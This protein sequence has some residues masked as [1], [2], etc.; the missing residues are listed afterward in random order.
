MNQ[1]SGNARAGLLYFAYGSN[2]SA[3]RLRAADRAPSAQRVAIGY[4]GG[5]R[6]AFDKVGR[7]DGS[8]KCDCEWTGR[9]EGA[10]RDL[11]WG[12]VWRIDAAERDALDRVEGLGNGYRRAR[13]VVSTDAGLLEA[14]TYLATSKDATLRPFDWYRRH[15]LEG[16]IEAGLPPEWID[17]IRSVATCEDPDRDRAL[18]ELARHGP[19]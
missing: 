4:V 7:V 9:T 15:V 18:R 17:A 16:A 6:L 14:D 19:A 8:G 11:V 13:V 5:Y 2:M 3:R 1:G 10:A 12:V